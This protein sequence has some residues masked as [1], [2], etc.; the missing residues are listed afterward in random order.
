LL[1]RVHPVSRLEGIGTVIIGRQYL[2][3][4]KALSTKQLALRNGLERSIHT[5]D[6]ISSSANA[7]IVDQPL[8]KVGIDIS[9]DS[10]FVQWLSAV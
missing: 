6:R 1:V 3:Q 8:N 10:S 7:R 9:F 2:V 5:M 4:T